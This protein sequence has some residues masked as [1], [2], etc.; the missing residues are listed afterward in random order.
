MVSQYPNMNPKTPLLEDINHFYNTE[1][2]K[3]HQTKSRYFSP[4][5]EIKFFSLLKTH[6]Y[7]DQNTPTF[8]S[9]NVGNHF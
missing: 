6:L 8:K 2:K 7:V 4:E 3:L 9:I 5:A 1:G